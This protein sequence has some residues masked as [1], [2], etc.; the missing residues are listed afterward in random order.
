MSG[1]VVERLGMAELPV[2]VAEID[3]ILDNLCLHTDADNIPAAARAA[4]R[5]DSD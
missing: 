5:T 2:V 4:S 3:D 1:Q